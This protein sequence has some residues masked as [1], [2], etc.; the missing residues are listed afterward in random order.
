MARCAVFVDAGLPVSEA[1]DPELVGRRFDGSGPTID[2]AIAQIPEP[3]QGY[4]WEAAR[5]AQLSS[6]HCEGDG[7]VDRPSSGWWASASL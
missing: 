6:G 5:E 1:F 7:L 3:L 2:E 4:C